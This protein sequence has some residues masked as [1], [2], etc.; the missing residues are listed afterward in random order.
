MVPRDY[1]GDLPEWFEE[2]REQ[3]FAADSDAERAEILEEFS[4]H[5]DFPAFFPDAEDFEDSEYWD[6]IFEEDGIDDPH[7]YSGDTNGEE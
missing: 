7:D 4:D 3:Y 5:A 6:D 1:G 2:L